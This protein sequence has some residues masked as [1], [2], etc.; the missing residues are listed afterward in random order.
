[1]YLTAFDFYDV[2]K[3]QK[4]SKSTWSALLWSSFWNGSKPFPPAFQGPTKTHYDVVWA[5]RAELYGILISYTK[6]N[7][8]HE[9]HN[10]PSVPALC[11]PPA[12]V[13]YEHYFRIQGKLETRG[14]QSFRGK[15][16]SI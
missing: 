6:W 10:T 9:W 4:V 16:R 5:W 13:L 2:L 12:H 7:E 14:M 1:M 11:D 3:I 8:W 15:I